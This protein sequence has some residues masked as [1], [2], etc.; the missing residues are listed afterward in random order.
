MII[1][2]RKPRVWFPGAIYHIMVRGNNKQNIFISDKDYSKFLSILKETQK[3]HP[4]ILHSYCL[5]TNHIHLQIETIDTNISSIMSVLLRNYS[6]YYNSEHE[7]IGHV[8]Q[9]CFQSLL[10]GDDPYFL[11]TNRYIH[12]NPYKAMIVSNPADYEYS[13]YQIYLGQSQA[14]FAS[15]ALMQVANHDLI[16]NSNLVNTEFTLKFFNGD[17][18]KYRLFVEGES[19]D[20]SIEDAIRADLREND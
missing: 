10:I 14:R 16:K 8:F 18:E 9:S 17:L 13:S 4:F 6:I 3:K 2:P 5:M 7:F 20:S 15:Q 12:L 1:I 19:A 11:Q